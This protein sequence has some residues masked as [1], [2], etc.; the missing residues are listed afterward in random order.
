[1]THES[2]RAWA[3]SLDDAR[4]RA[5]DRLAA[6]GVLE[7]LPG[8]A[9]IVEGVRAFETPGHAP[10]HMSLEVFGHGATTVLAGDVAVHPAQLDHPAWTY[11]HEHDGELAER[12]RRAFLARTAGATVLYAHV[13][14]GR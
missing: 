14:P 9:E 4:S 6:A 13:P 8:D 12:T 1:M 10:G 11:V 2:G 7:L 5:L 3:A